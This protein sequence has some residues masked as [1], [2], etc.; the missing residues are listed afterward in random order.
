MTRTNPHAREYEMFTE[1]AAEHSLSVVHD[2]GLDRRLRMS[3]DGATAWSWTVVTW[4]GYL[5]VVGDIADGY[6]FSRIADMLDFFDSA[7]RDRYSD[8]CPVID[9]RYWAEKLQGPARGTAKAYSARAFLAW[10]AERLDEHE[11]L[12]EEAI[13][14]LERD[15]QEC[16]ED[17]WPAERL[18]EIRTRRQ[19]VLDQARCSSDT[20]HSAIEWV[21]AQ[22]DNLVGDPCDVDLRD[23]DVHFLYACWAIEMTV[24]AYREHVER[25]GAGDGFALV[26]GGLVQNEPGFPVYDMDALDSDLPPGDALGEVVD[27][28]DRMVADPNRRATQEPLEELL[29]YIERHGDPEADVA[30]AQEAMRV[31]G[32]YE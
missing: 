13:A 12:G 27:L 5:A 14:D 30:P 22:E 1:Q 31:R 3:K 4:P 18:A 32:S 6:V 28:F 11:D 21:Y 15:A 25:S 16:P 2:A 19:E 17:D 24:R 8:G 20:E 9:L 7:R 26:R 10:V 23:W 29:A